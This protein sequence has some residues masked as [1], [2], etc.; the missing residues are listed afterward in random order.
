MIP[1][2]PSGKWDWWAPTRAKQSDRNRWDKWFNERYMQGIPAV[3]I[4]K[5]RPLRLVS[6]NFEPARKVPSV[7]KQEMLE[8]VCYQA[9]ME[10]NSRNAWSNTGGSICEAY[11]HWTKTHDLAAAFYTIATTDFPQRRLSMDR[12]FVKLYK[13]G[14]VTG[15]ETNAADSPDFMRLLAQALGKLVEDGKYESDWEYQFSQW[16][17]QAFNINAK[18]NGYKSDVQEIRV[19]RSGYS[20]FSSN[21]E[22]YATPTGPSAA[23]IEDINNPFQEV[24][25]SGVEPAL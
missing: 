6:L 21:D 5:S 15:V 7:H 16:L 20:S 17:P 13:D 4:G 3:F 14:N 9:L 24:E 19:L 25:A 2:D 23:I 18:L 22:V 8:S 10:S 12:E 11:V 1:P